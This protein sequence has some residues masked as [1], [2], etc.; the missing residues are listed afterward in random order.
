MTIV[1]IAPAD[2]AGAALPAA[3]AGAACATDDGSTA[4]VADIPTRD[5]ASRR[6]PRSGSVA[7]T[8]AQS[9]FATRGRC[10]AACSS[11]RLYR[12]AVFVESSSSADSS[13]SSASYSSRDSC[14]CDARMR[15]AMARWWR[16]SS[17]S[18]SRACTSVRCRIARSTWANE[19]VV[20]D[21][22]SRMAVAHSTSLDP[23]AAVS[24]AIS[25]ASRANRS[26][27][28]ASAALQ[29]VSPIGARGGC[30]V[31][32]RRA[33]LERRA[34]RSSRISCGRSSSSAASTALV[35]GCRS[36]SAP[37][38][39][40]QAAGTV[41]RTLQSVT[42]HPSERLRTIT[43]R[44]SRCGSPSPGRAAITAATSCRSVDT[45]A[46]LVA[47]RAFSASI[48][49]GQSAAS[50]EEDTAQITRRRA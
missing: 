27:V 8:V 33:C 25:T 23:A 42:V 9:A 2:A 43:S 21:A 38:A 24:A 45:S 37:S 46:V 48:A 16:G 18:G 39:R 3:G 22:R 47:S 31:T 13:Q 6:H 29:C 35:C 34:R 19:A 20:P 11:A 1:G 7:A 4:T 30:G 12:T 36:S 26:A 50:R 49:S 44:H 14:R 15:W 28:P 10:S 17:S 32:G 41:S 5:S 40:R